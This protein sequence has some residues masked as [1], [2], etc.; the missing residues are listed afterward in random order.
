MENNS[1]EKRQ[2][3]AQYN[4]KR[5]PTVFQGILAPTLM[6][7]VSSV[8]IAIALLIADTLFSFKTEFGEYLSSAV[9]S[10]FFMFLMLPLA[11]VLICKMDGLNTFRLKKG[12]DPIQLLLL[13]VVSLGLFFIAQHVNAV[14]ISF[15][16]SFL[17]TPSSITDSPE[18]QN[19]WQL[20]YSIVIIAGLPAICEEIMFRG[21]M[22]RAFERKSALAA[23][24]FSSAAFSI[25]HGNL[26]QIVY[27]FLLGLIMGLF[28]I[29][30]D[31]LAASITLHFTLNTLTCLMMYPPIFAAY[32]TLVMEYPFLYLTLMV[33]LTLLG[34]AAALFLIKYT[35][36]K[37]KRKFGCEMVSDMCCTDLMP[38][39]KPWEKVLSTLA[40]V[41]FIG[42]NL[43]SMI[44]L[45]FYDDIMKFLEQL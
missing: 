24:M 29:L 1:L 8:P 11:F 7:F 33:L 26:Q 34:I 10:Q 37:N 41:S 40:W 6:Y 25:M 12:I 27:A 4:H 35:K 18:A 36:K 2:I 38:K 28:V 19:I 13:I 22:L 21:F 45:W 15:I 39:P 30:T 44:E 31:S 32:E 3:Q 5:F 14:F 43:L 23:V 17:G 20:L 16:A 42:V 9:I